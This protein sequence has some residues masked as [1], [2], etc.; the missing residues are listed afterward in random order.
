MWPIYQERKLDIA[1]SLSIL[2]ATLTPVALLC[3][4][5]ID[6]NTSDVSWRRSRDTWRCCRSSS[7]V[8]RPCCWSVSF[9]QH[10]KNCQNTI[11][12]FMNPAKMNRWRAC[13]LFCDLFGLASKFLLFDFKTRCHLL[14]FFF[15]IDINSFINKKLQKYKLR[16]LNQSSCFN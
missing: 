13:D 5:L 10:S 15:F 3:F 2:D 7:S 4:A 8:N 14:F 6:R 1:F 16:W 9:L 11:K 12:S